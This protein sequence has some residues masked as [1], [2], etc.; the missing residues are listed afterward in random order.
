[1][2]SG[3]EN[4]VK[5]KGKETPVKEKAKEVAAKE[6]GKEAPAKETGKE[7]PATFSIPEM[8]GGIKAN[9]NA[10]IRVAYSPVAEEKLEQKL[11][12]LVVFQIFPCQISK[13]LIR[14]VLHLCH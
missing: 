2:S 6:K 7:I 14:E 3:K 13:F 11:T 9:D 1:V 4:P 8:S 12:L 10:I 5:G